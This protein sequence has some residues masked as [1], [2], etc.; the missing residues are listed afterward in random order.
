MEQQSE[1]VTT[2][3]RT[4]GN[5]HPPRAPDLP[6]SR[7]QGRVLKQTDTLKQADSK[8]GREHRACVF[9]FD[10][11]QRRKTVNLKLKLK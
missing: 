9:P 5:E 7:L 1:T 4:T 3:H 11:T 10:E 8:L 2:A 6:Y